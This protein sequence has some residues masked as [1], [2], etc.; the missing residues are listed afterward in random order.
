LTESEHPNISAELTRM[1]EAA[2]YSSQ[3]QF[4]SAK[5]W[6]G[7]N[8][9]LGVPAAGLAAI[10]GTAVL[11]DSWSA[12]TGAVVA[13]VAGALAAIMTTINAAQRAE[14]SQT[15]ANAYLALQS[16]VR[17]MRSIDLPGL[18]HDEARQRLEELSQRRKAI[19]ETA[20]VPAFLAYVLGKRNIEKG[21]QLYEV[22]KI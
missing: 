16:D 1:E 10:A 5:F 6:R 21:R 3:T 20:P 19:N 18:E 13:L 9:C 7:L 11:A 17:M 4:S 14:Q 2:T 22:D 8:L 12:K 15:S